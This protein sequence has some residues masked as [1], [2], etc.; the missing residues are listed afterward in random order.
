MLFRSAASG[1]KIPD[2]TVEKIKSCEI[3]YMILPKGNT[4]WSLPNLYDDKEMLFSPE[5]R[6]EFMNNYTPTEWTEF[7]QLWKCRKT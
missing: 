2:A 4:P 3:P 5:I 6:G 7:Y 1:I